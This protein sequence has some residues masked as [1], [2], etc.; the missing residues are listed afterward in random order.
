MELNPDRL[1]L[2]L[3]PEC[4]S[5]HCRHVRKFKEESYVLVDIGGGTVDIVSHRIANG[6]L[7]EINPPKGNTWG[8]AT[9]NTTF[10]KFIGE[11]LEDPNFSS[12]IGSDVKDNE[13]R[14][15]NEKDLDY[16]INKEF[17]D[18]KRYFTDYDEG[19]C[20]E[21][22]VITLPMSFWE[23]YK[24]KMKVIEKE[25]I[26]FDLK[27]HELTIYKEKMAELF[28]PTI[29]E[30]VSLVKE[31]LQDGGGIIKDVFLAGGFGGCQYVKLKLQSALD[32]MQQ[33]I[34]VHPAPPEGELGI[35]HGALMFRC[36]PSTIHKR[37]ADATY[38]LYCVLPFKPGV[39]DESKKILCE[40]EKEHMCEDLFC[41][42]VERGDT[43]I[44]GSVF[45]SSFI[46]T[47]ANHSKI[48]FE[49]YVSPNTNVWYVTEPCVQKLGL[50]TL[51][52]HSVGINQKME[53]VFDF[54]HAEIQ[55][56][57]YDKQNPEYEKKTV[58]DFL[59]PNHV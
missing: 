40:D 33:N 23:K 57:C 41:T 42:I 2:A 39:H 21:S 28:E 52:L 17:E 47:T 45:V 50:F 13:I 6:H 53:V 9:V 31:V 37:K 48:I 35:V 4:A 8:G 36:N 43:I 16:F 25:G 27:Q 51:D 20:P 1:S 3:E 54:T 19:E 7:E 49:V 22:F 30:I 44:S 18:I 29:R 11:A 14:T 32:E 12:Y 46:T 34:Q 15:G 24:E 56:R 26:S 10:Q 55:V 58:V 59:D 38:G 5:L